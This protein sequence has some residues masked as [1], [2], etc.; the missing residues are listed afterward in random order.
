MLL[1]LLLLLLLLYMLKYT[2]PVAVASSALTT[3][4]VTQTVREICIGPLAT[5]RSA[6][7]GRAARCLISALD[8][9]F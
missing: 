4:N 9:V 1:L 5:T 8:L 6:A 7:Y 2:R 3:S